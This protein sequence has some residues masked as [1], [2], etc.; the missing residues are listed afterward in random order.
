MTQHYTFGDTQRAAQRLHRLADV[1]DAYSRQLLERYAPPE[2]TLAVDLGAGIGRTTAL[3]HDS[4]RAE[5]TVGLEA[6]E[7]FVTIARAESNQP[8]I[9]FI[10]HDITQQPF[11]TPPAQVLFSRFLLTHLSAPATVLAAVRTAALPGASLLCE[12]TASLDCDSPVFTRYYELV[13]AMQEH[14]GQSLGIGRDLA[15]LAEQGGWKVREAGVRAL[16]LRAAAMAE[17]HAMN[18]AT[19]KSDPYAQAHFDADELASLE[20]SLKAIADGLESCSPVACGFAYL[21]AKRQR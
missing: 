20:R 21:V 2:V 5:R 8:T 17:L 13:A 10:Q 18:I 19:W 6:S 16:E 7:R 15:A 11:P 1:F 12:E 9:E 3:L 14:Y 4:I